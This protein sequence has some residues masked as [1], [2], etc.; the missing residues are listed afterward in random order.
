MLLPFSKRCFS[1]ILWSNRGFH[2]NTSRHFKFCII[3]QVGDQQIESS[4]KK[5]LQYLLDAWK[6]PNGR[7]DKNIFLLEYVPIFS[8]SHLLEISKCQKN[9]RIKLFFFIKTSRSSTCA[10]LDV[11]KSH[12]TI[13]R[14]WLGPTLNFF[15]WE[16][17]NFLLKKI[18]SW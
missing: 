9:L 15:S 8:P 18:S 13:K 11:G 4:L 5:K 7:G 10:G 6:F 2:P 17:C 12:L 16:K 14:L 1:S 3:I